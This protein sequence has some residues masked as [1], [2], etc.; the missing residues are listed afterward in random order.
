MIFNLKFKS[1]LVLQTLLVLAALF[2]A[3]VTLAQVLEI[4]VDTDSGVITFHNPTA[5]GVEFDLY[6]I[7]SPAGGLLEGDGSWHSFSDQGLDGIGTWFEAGTSNQS[8][9][10][11]LAA[12]GS[13]TID[14]G[15]IF[16]IGSAY[17]T[18]SDSRDLEFSYLPVGQTPLVLGVVR[19]TAIPEPSTLLLG[20]LAGTRIL[21]RRKQTA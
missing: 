18:S 9:L 14:P 5:S 10:A 7:T 20:V 2:S 16:N 11:E 21:M 12:I 13:S 19:Y 4:E 17:N 3:Q 6:T 8:L 15:E 1:T